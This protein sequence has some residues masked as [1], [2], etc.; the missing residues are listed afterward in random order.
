MTIFLADFMVGVGFV[1]PLSPSCSVCAACFAAS[2]AA[3]FPGMSMCPGI[4]IMVILVFSVSISLCIPRI[5]CCPDW[6]KGFM[7]D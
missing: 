2:S 5:I 6:R 7:M 3:S 1:L 4:Q